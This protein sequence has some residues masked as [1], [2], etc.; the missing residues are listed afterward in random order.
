MPHLENYLES[1]TQ[2][3]SV[4]AVWEDFQD[5]LYVRDRIAGVLPK[6]SH[7]PYQAFEILA[8]VGC[9]LDR[10]ENLIPAVST[11]DI[12]IWWENIVSG[13]IVPVYIDDTIKLISMSAQ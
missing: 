7:P 11:S 2:S 3:S 12:E 13:Y 10:P 4:I 5:W 8:M 9:I 1:T 6:S